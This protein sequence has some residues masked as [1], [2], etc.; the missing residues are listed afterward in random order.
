MPR[1]LSRRQ[2]FTFDLRREDV[3]SSHWVRVHRQAMACRFEVTLPPNAAHQVA[4]ARAALDEADRVEARLTVFRD[5]SELTRINRL[6]ASGRVPIDDELFELL[7]MSQQLSMATGGAFDITSTPLSRCWGF[8][9][10][11]GRMPAARDIENARS[12]VGMQLVELDENSRTVHFLRDDVELNLGSIGKGYALGRMARVLT[13][14]FVN[15]AL[16]S[17]GGSSI[18]ALGHD[19]GKGD[20]ARGWVVDV[21]SR[22][23]G[24]DPLARL[25]FERRFSAAAD[26]HD[27][28][29]ALAT[30][31]SGEQF[32]DVDG[33]RYG[34]VFD[35]RTGWPARGVVSVSV[36]ADDP[37]VADALSTAFLVGGRTLAEEYCAA[38]PE[39]L[40][41]MTEDEP[42]ART[43]IIG[44]HRR[45]SA[46]LP[47]SD[48]ARGFSRT[49]EDP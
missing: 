16:I 34:H 36:V 22:R 44:S 46:R 24:R 42:A 5:T 2:L 32:V 20:A 10:R 28:P 27:T 15:N 19:R 35:P 8:L 7:Q 45:C 43:R 37:A 3:G 14:A 6:A 9:R 12:R 18:F 23:V 39:T 1:T 40:V 31:G 21:K 4:A 30:S 29:V 13:G 38:H 49:M 48:G 11:E 41:L 33:V 25:R 26:E 47:P 17:A